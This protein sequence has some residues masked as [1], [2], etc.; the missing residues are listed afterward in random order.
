MERAERTETAAEFGPRAVAVARE[1]RRQSARFQAARGFR[2]LRT[3]VLN[4]VLQPGF[5]RGQKREAGDCPTRARVLVAT[6][7][8]VGAEP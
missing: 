1:E 2:P 4:L 5:R 8:Q 6:C 7:S 3:L